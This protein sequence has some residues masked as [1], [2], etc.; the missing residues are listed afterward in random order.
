MADYIARKLQKFQFTLPRGERQGAAGAREPGRVVSIHAPAWGATRA[1]TPARATH[2]G[3]N[4]RSRVGSDPLPSVCIAPRCP[5]QFTL[6][7][8]ERRIAS[9]HP[10]SRAWFQFTLPRGERPGLTAKAA[11]DLL[12]SIHAPAWGA[13]PAAPDDAP[14]L[15]R[16]NSRSRVGSD[17]ARPCQRARPWR[18]NSRSR[19][20]SDARRLHRHRQRRGFNSR[21]RVGSDLQPRGRPRDGPGFNS[22]SRVGSD[23]AERLVAGRAPRFNS[24]SR[25]GSD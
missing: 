20:G 24:R 3:F 13:T 14:G 19:V 25:V 9:N 23:R 7:R 11:D 17:A 6:P 21:S 4:S 10:A 18:F 8:G 5:F 16:F 1:V 12:V 15:R 22:R 2:A